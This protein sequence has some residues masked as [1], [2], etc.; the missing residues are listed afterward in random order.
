[1][2]EAT[3]NRSLPTVLYVHGFTGST[4]AESVTEVITAYIAH[5]GY[6]ILALDWGP[7]AKGIYVTDM[8]NVFRVGGRMAKVLL[9]LFNA[10]L[11]IETFHLLG[12]SLGGQMAGVIGENVQMMTN[13]EMILERITALDPAGPLWG[14]SLMGPRRIITAADARFVDIIHTDA[15]CW[16]YKKGT[17][18]VDFWPNEGKNFQPGCKPAKLLSSINQGI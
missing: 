3:F 17:G 18:T 12:F 6:N 9:D 16:G 10:G 11:V 7:L 1:M 2:D 15:G 4:K 8:V 13:G 5:G 14:D